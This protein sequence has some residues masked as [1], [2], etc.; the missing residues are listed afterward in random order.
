M[1]ICRSAIDGFLEFAKLPPHRV[2]LAQNAIERIVAGKIIASNGN[3]F[4]YKDSRFGMV[5]LVIENNIV[6]HTIFL[7]QHPKGI[8]KI[9]HSRRP[10][11]KNANSFHH[12]AWGAHFD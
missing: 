12:T 7:K 9:H 6:K 10:R 2:E 1:Y 5:I 4:T 11:R 3:K 8:H